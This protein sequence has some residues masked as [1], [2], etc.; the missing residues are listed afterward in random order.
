MMM[1]TMK[2]GVD[3]GLDL[4][5]PVFPPFTYIFIFSWYAYSHRVEAG[6]IRV[7]NLLSLGSCHL[8]NLTI[9]VAARSELVVR[10]DY[11]MYY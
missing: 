3:E 2:C 1:Y 8:W 5:D 10:S 6:C 11:L 4:H 7:R 9:A